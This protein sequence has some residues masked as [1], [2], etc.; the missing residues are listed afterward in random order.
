MTRV[1]IAANW[2]EPN[3]LRQTPGCI[4]VWEGVEFTLDPISNPDY[5]I[6][7][8]CAPDNSTVECDPERVWVILMEPPDGDWPKFH[9]GNSETRRIYTTDHK[10]IGAK[11][12][13]GNP[14]LPWQVDRTYDQLLGEKLPDKPL[15]LSWIT[16]SKSQYRGHK[17]RLKFLKHLKSQV[18]FDLFGQGFQPIRD[19]WD[20]L[21]PYKYSLAVEN[22]RNSWYWTEKISDCF[23]SWTMPIYYGC[24]QITR[25]F[26]KEALIE[27]D[28]EDPDTPKRVSEV[29]QSDRWKRNLDAIAYARELVLKRYQ[30][31]PVMRSEIAAYET[32]RGVIPLPSKAIDLYRLTRPRITIKSRIISRLHTIAG[33]CQ[34]IVT[35]P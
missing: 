16:S 20:A 17:K 22:Y 28:I 3:I 8:N 5:M 11:Y 7:I 33:K 13:Y 2:T 35:K 23:L 31:F 21:A 15:G 26:P 1:R 27:I 6:V 24:T 18:T 9:R 12:F 14:T 29:I 30:F 4:G 32:M 19:K 25:F 10:Q 34:I